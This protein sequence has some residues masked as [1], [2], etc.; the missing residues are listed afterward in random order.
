MTMVIVIVGILL[1]ASLPLIRTLTQQKKH[2]E[3]VVGLEE[4][5]NAL[6]GYAITH[7]GFPEPLTG[8]IVPSGILGVRNLGPYA[9]AFFYDVNSALTM[10]STGSNVSN[11]CAAVQTVQKA[12]NDPALPM[13]PSLPKI[14]NGT[15]YTVVA[16]V[17]P[18]N[19]SLS[20]NPNPVAFVLIG[21]G[22]NYK[23]DAQNTI[24]TPDDRTY[25]NPA[26]ASVTNN[27]DDSVVSY[28]LTQLTSL[29][30]NNGYSYNIQRSSPSPSSCTAGDKQRCLHLTNSGTVDLYWYLGGDSHN[31]APCSLLAPGATITAGPNPEND[32]MVVSLGI[33]PSTNMCLTDSNKIEEQN[34][35]SIDAGSNTDAYVTCNGTT[36]KCTW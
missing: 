21:K 22:Q 31:P 19:P 25:E 36:K 4:I 32:K 1:S 15:S 9:T 26:K 18:P 30:I 10:T 29:C 7:G 24:T 12:F 23:L 3:E 27:Y 17:T 35:N 16:P 20:L 2:V 8:N 5:K 13:Q 28:S 33:N 11:F 6:I 34:I 14:W